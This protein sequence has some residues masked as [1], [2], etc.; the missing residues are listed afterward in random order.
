MSQGRNRG[1]RAETTARLENSVVRYVSR[2]LGRTFNW[3]S[4]SEKR[5]QRVS[6]PRRNDSL[7]FGNYWPSNSDSERRETR[8][9][10][11][12]TPRWSKR[13]FI[14]LFRFAAVRRQLPYR[15]G[16]TC[17]RGLVRS[18]MRRITNWLKTNILQREGEGRWNS[19]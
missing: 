19:R 15:T 13:V 6:R 8:K 4:L 12:K 10:P 18:V 2:E 7:F 9:R 5:V 14:R 16:A 11:H 1:G 17:K 3:K